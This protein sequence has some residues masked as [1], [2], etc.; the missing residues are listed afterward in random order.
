MKNEL[1]ALKRADEELGQLIRRDATMRAQLLEATLKQAAVERDVE[2]QATS[3]DFDPARATE[4]S[5]RLTEAREARRI[6]ELAATHLADEVP[7]AKIRCAA[8]ERECA[9]VH[10]RATSAELDAACRKFLR[11][12]AAELARLTQLL[13]V[14][15]AADARAEFG[16]DRRAAPLPVD[17]LFQGALFEAL[18]DEL[19]HDEAFQGKCVPEDRNLAHK[20]ENLTPGERSICHGNQH[21]PAAAIR[22]LLAAAE[23]HEPEP[24]SP[25]VLAQRVAFLNDRLRRVDSE[26]ERI[27]SRTKRFA[28]HFVNPHAATDKAER[29]RLVAMRDDLDAQRDAAQQQ[30]MAMQ[31]AA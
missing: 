8:A 13:N 10:A 1:Q 15:A 30:L 16:P 22:E 11:A 17:Q 26:L 19:G 6:I 23:P 18:L 29:E 4:L 12:N 25:Q 2:R 20:A 5:R 21:N 27:D 24:D 28:G 14:A 31:E 7:G 9:K 3:E